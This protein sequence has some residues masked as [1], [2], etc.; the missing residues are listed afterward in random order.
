MISQ[1]TRLR[2]NLD[3]FLWCIKKKPPFLIC[4]QITREIMHSKDER[5]NT[6][7]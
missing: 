4:V 6:G 3:L 2:G 1:H 5:D 7:E